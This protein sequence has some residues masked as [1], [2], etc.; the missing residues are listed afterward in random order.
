MEELDLCQPDY[1]IVQ[2]VETPVEQVDGQA[3]VISEFDEF[4]I[5]YTTGRLP[6]SRGKARPC[7][8]RQAPKQEMHHRPAARIT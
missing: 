4:T 8:I 5:W 3:P 7:V 1:V 2:F 6:Q